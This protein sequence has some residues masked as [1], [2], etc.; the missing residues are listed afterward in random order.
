M[1]EVAETAVF[2]FPPR[3]F[4]SSLVGSAR[5][6]WPRGWRTS[7]GRPWEGPWATRYASRPGAAQPPA[8][9]SAPVESSSGASRPTP[10]SRVRAIIRPVGLSPG[11]WCGLVYLS[12]LAIVRAC[13]KRDWKAETNNGEDGQ[14]C[15]PC[16][17]MVDFIADGN[18]N[19]L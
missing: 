18:F 5:S 12:T 14:W 13:E 1:A 19:L 6:A 7:A 15:I 9:S 4:T 10:S 16:D 3:I 8:S 2:L 17:H 11:R